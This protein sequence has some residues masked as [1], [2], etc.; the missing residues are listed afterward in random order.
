MA[1]VVEPRERKGAFRPQRIPYLRIVVNHSLN[2]NLRCVWCHREGLR[3]SERR[4]LLSVEEIGRYAA[5]MYDLGTRKF[6]LV[7]GEPTL[8]ADL[9]EILAEIRAIDA[10]IDLSMVTNGT[11]LADRVASYVES[12]L[13]RVNVSVFTLRRSY[14]E[15]NV[16]PADMLDSTIAGVDA[17]VAL[18]VCGKINHVFHDLED[19][20]SIL[21]FARDRSVRVN[22]LN[23]IPSLFSS[24]GMS[25]DD[26]RLE[27]LRLPIEA[28]HIED[29]PYSLPVEVLTLAD[30]TE[31]EFKHLEI[32]D[33]GLFRGCSSC[34]VRSSCK[35]GIYALRLTPSGQLQPCMV[36]TDN[37]FNLVEGSIAD[38]RTYL[39]E[40]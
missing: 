7:G 29:D 24:D 36:R 10:H 34:P 1:V 16:G 21:A 3:H 40:V 22:V 26:L 35:E 32:G 8:R 14:F 39:A 12:G 28:S 15:L 17:A 6:K 37:T 18:G 31:M 5:A 11:L 23:R 19:L 25:V 2:C 4:F 20:K 38:L 27:L 30:G 33:Q 13:D 9:A